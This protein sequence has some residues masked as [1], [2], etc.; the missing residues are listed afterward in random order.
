MTAATLQE[1]KMGVMPVGKLI[2]NMALPMVISM[3]VQALYNVVDSIYVSQVSE[4][5]I[6]IPIS[7]V[8]QLT[9]IKYVLTAS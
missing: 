6:Q 8:V 5:G 7:P 4:S 9:T 2:A 3:L 1:N